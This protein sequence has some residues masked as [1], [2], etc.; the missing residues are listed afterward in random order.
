MKVVDSQGP[1]PARRTT[2]V[3]T[4][5]EEITRIIVNGE[6]NPGD[7]LNEVEIAKRL[8]VSRGP[9]R[10][11][12]RQ[13]Q[14]IG[15]LQVQ[16]FR[17]S[18]VRRLTQ[19]EVADIY[20]LRAVLECTAAEAAV[21]LAEA[22][23]LT[24]LESAL[25]DTETA[26]FSNAIGRMIEADVTFHTAL[27]RAGHNNRITETFGKLATEL[28]LVHLLMTPSAN[29]MR[30][31]A[32]EHAVI[33]DA[34]RA[35]SGD[36]TVGAVRGHVL[37][38]RDI[39]LQ[40]LGPH[41]YSDPSIADADSVPEPKASK[42]AGK[43]TIHPHAPTD[44]PLLARMNREL[45]DDEGHRNAMTIPELE[46]R[47]RRFVDEDGFSVDLFRIND[48]IVGYATYRREPDPAD[49]KGHR[50]YLR[51]FY[52]VRHY[53]REGLGQVAF[54]ALAAARFRPGE[55]IILEAIDNNPGG[56]AFWLRVGFTSYSTILEHVVR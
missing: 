22:S 25:H 39:I 31:A 43:V 23:D 53:R 50:V 35:R 10:E 16:P 44:F 2:L 9:V 29:Q 36:R 19:R 14:E 33:L 18:F 3:E 20:A 12:S 17:G 5:A 47:F 15:L 55:R 30:A 51:Q 46:D 54:H 45:A 37:R 4:V 56:R 48:E 38:E 40:Y 24:A 26:A 34:L 8:G 1:A 13:L 42:Y 11:A 52:I 6:L 28:R 21:Q 27:C 32:R 7:K 49:L 41:G